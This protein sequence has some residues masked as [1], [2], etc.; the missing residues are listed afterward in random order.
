MAYEIDG[1][2]PIK[3]WHIVCAE[4]ATIEHPLLAK[5][6]AATMRLNAAVPLAAISVLLVSGTIY[7]YRVTDKQGRNW[8]QQIDMD[9]PADPAMNWLHRGKWRL[10]EFSR[11]APVRQLI[12]ELIQS[13][14]PSELTV[15][16]L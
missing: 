1:S 4:P 8:S 15:T 3:T 11:L 7:S 9:S 16:F 10:S 12:T 6:L 14:K 5:C 2:D 13:I